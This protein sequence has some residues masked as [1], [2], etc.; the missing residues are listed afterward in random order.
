MFDFVSVMCDRYVN[1]SNL[2]RNAE[3]WCRFINQPLLCLRTCHSFSWRT[4]Y[5]LFSAQGSIQQLELQHETKYAA[6]N[7]TASKR[8]RLSP[9]RLTV[10]FVAV[11]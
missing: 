4:E 11:N 1:F 7:A 6:K 10:P 9:T 2:T 5:I 8:K 3:L